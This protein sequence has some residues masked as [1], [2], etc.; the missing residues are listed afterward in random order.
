MRHV[1]REFRPLQNS[2]GYQSARQRCGLF[3]SR[4]L[5]RKFLCKTTWKT[6]KIDSEKSENC[7]ISPRFF[8]RVLEGKFLNSVDFQKFWLASTTK[9]VLFLKLNEN[10]PWVYDQIFSVSENSDNKRKI[11]LHFATKC[12]QFLKSLMTMVKVSLRFATKSYQFVKFLVVMRKF[13]LQFTTKSD[14]F[15]KII[16]KMAWI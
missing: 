9:F 4:L 7:D 1:F 8:S 3:D 13:S 2:Y 16:R 5:A 10:F 12:Y 14:Y 15:L 11:S 6:P